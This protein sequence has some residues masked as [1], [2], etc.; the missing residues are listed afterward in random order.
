MNVYLDSLQTS[1]TGPVG[2]AFSLTLLGAV[3][4]GSLR[5]FQTETVRRRKAP[6]DTSDIPRE[7]LIPV[8]T[9][10]PDLVARAAIVNRTN[11]LI[12]ED[13]WERL[14]AEIAAWERRLDSTPGGTRNHEL[15]VDTALGALRARLDDAAR[16]SF[17]DLAPARREADRF[18]ARARRAPHD[19]ILA[20]LAARSQLMLAETCQA[21]FWPDELRAKAWRNMA[22][23]YLQA[24]GLLSPFD[25]VAYMSPL[26]AQACYELALGLPDGGR[27]VRPAFEDWIDLD[28][29]NP[30]IY[31]A[32]MPKLLDRPDVTIEDI[33]SE[34]AAAATRTE[35]T[36]GEGGFAL[37]LLPA[38]EDCEG[39]RE[40]MATDRFAAGLM[41][42]ARLS[43]TQADVNTAASVLAREM[44]IGSEHRRKTLQSAFDALVRRHLG[45]IYPRFWSIGLEDIRALLRGTYARTG[46][47]LK[48]DSP[49][50]PV[51]L[52]R[53][54]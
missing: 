21:D 1:L 11:H 9:N 23:Y 36:L 30:A 14:S 49:L 2:L 10:D 29:S 45:V 42:L 33:L 27:R 50:Y 8:V 6:M 16:N 15:A 44:G 26:L 39:L 7:L 37:C 17:D 41:D 22:H 38:L 3:A 32:H 4:V 28:P 13:D 52:A 34:A 54:A 40:R 5:R 48:S 43:G 35:E 24:E 12:S 47:P 53:A 18:M 20:V 31:A 19:H 46:G 51:D 25:P